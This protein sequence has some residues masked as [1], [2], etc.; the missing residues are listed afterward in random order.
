MKSKAY[1][2][3]VILL[4]CLFSLLTNNS[5]ADDGLPLKYISGCEMDLTNDAVLDL[6][7]LMETSKGIQLFVLI[8]IDDAYSSQVLGSYDSN[9]NMSCRRG[10]VLYETR[11]GKGNKQAAKHKTLGSYVLISQPEGAAVAYYFDGDKFQTVWV[12]D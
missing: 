6:A 10:D 11:A 1:F 8:K 3:W 5:N 4:V 7:F 9:V 12:K 2:I